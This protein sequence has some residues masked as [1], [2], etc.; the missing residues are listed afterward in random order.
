[1]IDNK[2]LEV[3]ADNEYWLQ[4]KPNFLVTERALISFMGVDAAPAMP[5]WAIALSKM[6]GILWIVITTEQIIKIRYDHYVLT[7]QDIKDALCKLLD[8][9]IKKEAI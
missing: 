9:T 5:E 3:L 8:C 4:L 1:M 2:I 6:R 7:S